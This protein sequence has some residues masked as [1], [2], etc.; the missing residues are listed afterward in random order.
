MAVH[1]SQIAKKQL[2]NLLHLHG[3]RIVLFSVV[4]GGCNGFKYQLEPIATG[5]KERFDEELWLTKDKTLRVCGKSLFYVLGT[6]IDW[7]DDFMGQSFVFT[8]PKMASTCGCGK[9]FSV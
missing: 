1:V 8:N 2:I 6:K 7:K 9:T 4:G 5:K 3:K